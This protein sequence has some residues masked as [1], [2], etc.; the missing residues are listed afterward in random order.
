[1]AKINKFKNIYF[2]V[3]F[4]YILKNSK[5][6]WW[7]KDVQIHDVRLYTSAIS[8]AQIAELYAMTP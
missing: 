8:N 6:N 7:A 3:I 1:M 2:V 5:W 4:M